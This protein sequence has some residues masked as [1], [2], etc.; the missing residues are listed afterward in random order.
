MKINWPLTIGMSV[1][2]TVLANIL[3]SSTSSSRLPL[4]GCQGTP[5]DALINLAL[6][7][8]AGY[9]AYLAWQKHE[10]NKRNGG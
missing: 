4:Q 5:L 7:G 1:G 9:I 6:L 10:Q 8:V 3:L 2:G